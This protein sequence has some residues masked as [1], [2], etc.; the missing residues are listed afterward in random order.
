V[1]DAGGVD[2]HGMPSIGIDRV[3]LV[4]GTFKP[5]L[6]SFMLELVQL[7]ARYLGTTVIA[8]FNSQA[9]KTSGD[10]AQSPLHHRTKKASKTA[11]WTSRFGPRTRVVDPFT[12]PSL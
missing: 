5:H 6:G 3:D 2:R 9:R 8:G 11:S 7:T 1:V 10:T 4:D 12:N